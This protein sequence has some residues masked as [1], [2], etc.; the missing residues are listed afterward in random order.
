MVSFTF[1]EDEYCIQVEH[2]GKGRMHYEN[3]SGVQAQILICSSRALFH[4]KPKRYQDFISVSIAVALTLKSY[5]FH[6]YYRGVNS[7][8]DSGYPGRV[9]GFVLDSHPQLQD[10]KFSS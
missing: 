9:L 4:M 6:T 2:T 7:A 8:C 5:N 3:L 1:I 10:I